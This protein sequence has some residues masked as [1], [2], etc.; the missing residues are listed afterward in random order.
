MVELVVFDRETSKMSEPSN[1]IRL[2]Y[3]DFKDNY[4][5]NGVVLETK[6]NYYNNQLLLCKGEKFINIKVSVKC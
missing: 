4:I 2:E 3:G 1:R 6:A 5:R